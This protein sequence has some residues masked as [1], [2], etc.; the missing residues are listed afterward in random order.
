MINMTKWKIPLFKIHTSFSDV[1]SVS[2]VIRRNMNWALGPEIEK[3]EKKLASYVGTKFCLTF[4]SGT[5]ALH[6]SLTS[7]GLK[8]NQEVI[9]PSFTFISTANSILMAGGMPHFVDIEKERLGLDPEQT[10]LSI[11]NN[12]KAIMPV[13]YAGS[14][15]K[16]EELRQIADRKKIYLIE[17]A[18]ESLGSKINKKKIGTFGDLSILSFAPNKIITT[19][20]GGAVLTNSKKLFEKLKL[21]RSHGRL[22][23][24]NY[25][26]SSL[27]P[28]YVTL[29]YNWRMP[30]M[31]A[32]LGISQLNRI[33]K[34]IS[35][36]RKKANFLFT[37]MK[38]F[39]EI[40]LPSESKNSRHVFQL[41]SIILSKSTRRTE[42][43][44][45]LA[46]K[47]IM[48]KV[49]IEPIH[50]TDFYKQIKFKQ[51]NLK[52]TEEISSRILEELNNG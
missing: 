48:T 52:N 31:V 26:S 19:G 51:S 29:G 41:Y 44:N 13:H 8:L 36:R 45:F 2:R 21:I 18:A 15:C 39:S 11:S 12:V 24:S 9:V 6:A 5:S 7:I 42:L 3:F 37:K 30:S 50:K 28:K 25:Y 27:K 10:E 20:E 17:D 32:A 14:P 22:E 4:N 35:M 46:K 40:T 33:E 43:M 47:G 34:L 1:S 16:I 49:Y 23:N 38:H